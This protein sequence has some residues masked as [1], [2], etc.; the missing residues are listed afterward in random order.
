[1]KLALFVTGEEKENNEAR[2]HGDEDLH[3]KLSKYPS[4]FSRDKEI[5]FTSSMFTLKRSLCP[6]NVPDYVD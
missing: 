5:A 3:E 1:M 2:G 4:R 6:E